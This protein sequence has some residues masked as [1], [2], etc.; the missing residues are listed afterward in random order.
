[1]LIDVEFDKSLALLLVHDMHRLASIYSYLHSMVTEK[2]RI[3]LLESVSDV[4]A[5][6][7]TTPVRPS[8]LDLMCRLSSRTD[9]E[10]SASSLVA[11]E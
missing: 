9:A 10:A 2:S 3:A 8:I 6:I 4:V 7:V 5:E 1:M 11:T